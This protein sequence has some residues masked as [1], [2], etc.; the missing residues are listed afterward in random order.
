MTTVI[1]LTGGIASG[2]STVS[3]MFATAG[4]PIIDAD[5]IAHEVVAPNTTVLADI[6]SVFGGTVLTATGQLDRHKLGN[7]VFN[8][9]DKLAE[10]NA[11]VQPV[12]RKVIRSRIDR[13][14]SQ[15]TPVVVL[16]APLLLEQHYEKDVD[17][18]VVVSVPLKIQQARLMARDNLSLAEANE[19][20]ESQLSLANKVAKADM[21]IDNSQQLEETRLQVVNLLD[22]VRQT[23][24]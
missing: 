19:R 18:I 14:R 16:D 3:K 23:A 15:N 24:D 12:I 9:D 1:G 17:M 22:K 11:I 4:I 5:K 13:F 21:I 8:D 10:L 20:I 2:K 6:V 7:L